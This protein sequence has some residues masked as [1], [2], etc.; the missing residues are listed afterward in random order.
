MVHESIQQDYMLSLK[1]SRTWC[2]IA[3]AQE[4]PIEW[5]DNKLVLSH[6]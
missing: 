3:T 4:L 1:H 5:Q 6:V 2:M